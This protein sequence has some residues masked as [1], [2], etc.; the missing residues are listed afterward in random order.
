MARRGYTLAI[1]NWVEP[2]PILP[3]KRLGPHEIKYLA[4]LAQVG[5]L[6]FL[7]ATSLVVQ[8][9]IFVPASDV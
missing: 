8:R 3:G 4:P 7:L 2:M 1:L 6:C 9:E 5:T